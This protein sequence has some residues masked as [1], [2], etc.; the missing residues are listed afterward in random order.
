MVII[1]YDKKIYHLDDRWYYELDSE[2]CTHRCIYAMTKEFA[3]IDLP[4]WR[5]ILEKPVYYNYRNY[6]KNIEKSRGMEIYSVCQS[7]PENVIDLYEEVICSRLIQVLKELNINRVEHSVAIPPINGDDPPVIHTYTPPIPPNLSK[8]EEYYY[9]IRDNE[10]GLNKLLKNLPSVYDIKG[11]FPPQNPEY[12]YDE[13]GFPY[14]ENYV[15]TLHMKMNGRMTSYV[16]G[17]YTEKDRFESAVNEMTLRIKQ[18]K[19]CL[20]FSEL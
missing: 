10:A 9:I 11:D 16:V 3:T 14:F 13:Y 1:G 17:Y 12:K 19:D 2:D 15:I 18:G 5:W 20:D 7:I 4:K 6:I 8:K